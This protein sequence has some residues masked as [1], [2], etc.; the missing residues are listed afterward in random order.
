MLVVVCVDFGP[1]VSV[2]GGRH[3]CRRRRCRGSR[4]W[5]R[6]GHRAVLGLGF[7]LAGTVNAVTGIRY[8]F[9]SGLRDL[10]GAF[11]AAAKD[12]LLDAGQC[13]SDF[14]PGL[15]FPSLQP[16]RAFVLLVVGG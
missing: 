3:I 13:G 8:S 10:L 12:S 7:D 4:V 2:T 14:V 11:F 16:P 6:P 9:E 5:S 15:V 1:V